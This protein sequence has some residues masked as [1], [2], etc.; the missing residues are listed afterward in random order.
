[1]LEMVSELQELTLSYFSIMFKHVQT[2][3]F[4][5]R[6][7][8]H[9]W[10]ETEDRRQSSIKCRSQAFWLRLLFWYC[11]PADSSERRFWSRRQRWE[12]DGLRWENG[13]KDVQPAV[14]C[15][16]K[17]EEH[18]GWGSKDHQE[19]EQVCSCWSAWWFNMDNWWR[20]VSVPNCLFS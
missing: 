8:C 17:I 13:K 9:C 15:L 2:T 16:W 12:T 18:L 3:V 10:G 11:W 1:M 7:C 14:L 4:R 19:E 6:C 5:H 20:F